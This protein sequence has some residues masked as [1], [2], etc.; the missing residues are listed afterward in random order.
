MPIVPKLKQLLDRSGVPYTRDKHRRA[1]DPCDTAAAENVRPNMMLKTVLVRTPD[2]RYA[3]AVLQASRKMFMPSL[4]HK[5]GATHLSIATEE[6][7]KALIP[8]CE[9]GAAPPFGEMYGLPVFVDDHVTR[10]E[11]VVFK[12][13]SHFDTICMEFADLERLVH[14][15]ITNFTDH[16]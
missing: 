3:I 4:A 8:D 12:A 10:L 14:P 1:V 2:G 15:T 6:E 9:V 7:T 13:G 16:F 5:L 11:H